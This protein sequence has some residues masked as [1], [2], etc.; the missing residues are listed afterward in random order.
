MHGAVDL[1]GHRSGLR[2]HD[3]AYAAIAGAHAPRTPAAGRLLALPLIVVAAWLAAALGFDRLHAVA[4]L[5]GPPVGPMRR[6]C[7]S[8]SR[9]VAFNVPPAAIRFKMQRRPARRRASIS[10]SCGRRW[11]RPT[12]PLPTVPT[13]HAA[14]QPPT[15]CSSPSPQR[16]HAAARRAARRRSIRAMS[17]P[18]PV[19]GPDG[20]AVLRVPQRHA[21]SGRGPDLRPAAPER[22]LVRCTATAPAPRRASACTSGGS[23]SA[24]VTVRFPR[25]WLDDWRAV[26]DGIERLIGTLRPAG[27]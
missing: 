23:A 15:G 10:A 9:G 5:A 25:E 16:R 21:L 11:S 1:Q 7:R 26:A 19:A 18:T 8:P 22:F 17:R 12:R 6:R 13:R 27:G 4:A 2:R 3:T 24:D 14:P 20:L